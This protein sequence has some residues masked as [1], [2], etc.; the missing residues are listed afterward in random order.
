[1]AIIPF[2]SLA[3]SVWGQQNHYTVGMT[4]VEVQC[5]PDTRRRSYQVYTTTL[6]HTV[7]YCPTTNYYVHYIV[8]YVIHCYGKE[9]R[10]RKKDLVPCTGN[11]DMK[12]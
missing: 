11:M 3:G 4:S 10:L 12:S 6:Y 9:I 2:S 1:M 5:D 7:P 8:H